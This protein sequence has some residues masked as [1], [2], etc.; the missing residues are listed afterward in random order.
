MEIGGKEF[1]NCHCVVLTIST[2]NVDITATA[3]PTPPTPT[4]TP[5]TPPSRFYL[6]SAGSHRPPVAF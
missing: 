5:T 2:Q 1:T 4:T 6:I 3:T